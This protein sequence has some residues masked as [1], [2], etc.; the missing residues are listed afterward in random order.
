MEKIW[1]LNLKLINIFIL[2][3][4][5]E[6]WNQRQNRLS[7]INEK[8]RDINEDHK[9]IYVYNVEKSYCQN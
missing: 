4:L 6:K 2:I 3:I 7:I 9:F 1:T 8:T 5:I